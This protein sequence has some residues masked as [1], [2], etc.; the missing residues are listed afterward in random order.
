M[1]T[2]DTAA[3]TRHPGPQPDVRR[4]PLWRNL[5]FQTLWI[6]ATTS[7]LG[8]SVADIAYPLTI[9]AITRSPAMAGLFAAV[10]ALGMLLAGLPAGVLADR[11]D[12]RT[13]VICTEA[14]RAVVTGAV[15]VALIMGYRSLPVLFAAAALLGIGQAVKGSAQMLLLRSVVPAE[16]LTQA[17]TQDEVRMNGAALAGPALGGALYAVRALAHAIPFLFTAGSFAAALVTA[18]LMKFAPGAA[19][20]PV[21]RPSGR[22]GNTSPGQAG[23]ML[24]GVRALWDQP[25]LRTA[26]LLIMCVNTIGAGLELIIIVLLRH[27]AVPSGTIGV[28]LGLGAAGGLAG[29]PLVKVLHRLRPGVLLLR[30]CLL[31]VLILGLLALPFGPWWVGGLMFTVMLGVPALRVLVDILVI[32][33]A[34]AEQ[35]GRVVAALMTMIGLGMPAGLAGCGLLLQNL[36]AQSA[37]LT[38]AAA[39]AVAVAYCATRR[40]LWQARWPGQGAGSAD[41]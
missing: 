9:L 30:M 28:A 41:T 27:Q 26:T 18:I 14:A 36:S 3:A 23:N 33:Q 22:A 32:R 13:I 4:V 21:D 17:L 8:V 24:A 7:T 16:Q 37:M 25:V 12:S 6:G 15:A 19:K 11:Y 35:R 34:P 2:A 39:E 10:Q 40:E 20:D 31:D 29:A 1:S 38:L 5:Q